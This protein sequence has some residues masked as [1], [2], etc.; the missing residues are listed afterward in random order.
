Q[1]AM[2]IIL[3]LVLLIAAVTLASLMCLQLTYHRRTIAILAMYGMSHRTLIGTF[4]VYGMV[5][6][7]MATSIGLGI[8]TLCSYGIDH[9]HLIT[10]PDI[11]YT[12]HIPAHMSWHIVG[13]IL[14]LACVTSLCV[15]WYPARS[16]RQI[17]LARS[18]TDA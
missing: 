7:L 4:I 17:P 11:Y 14:F 15:S 13:T 3:I 18:L 12:A 2:V 16:I 5:I 9:Y 1:R 10:L 6:T 8:A